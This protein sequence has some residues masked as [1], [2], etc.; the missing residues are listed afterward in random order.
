MNILGPGQ[1]RRWWGNRPAL[2]RQQSL[3]ADQCLLISTQDYPSLLQ[4]SERQ[5]SLPVDGQALQQA[6]A[7]YLTNSWLVIEAGTRCLNDSLLLF[8]GYRLQHPEIQV[9]YSDAL[10]GDSVEDAQLLLK[11]DCN[12]D[13]L[14]SRHYPGE[15]MLVT[16]ECIKR[17]LPQISVRHELIFCELIW[18]I[19]EHSGPAA[20]GHLP[21]A[22]LRIPERAVKDTHTALRREITH[23]HL[24]RCCSDS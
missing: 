19:L 21:E 16:G 22:L 4:G 11:P 1:G 24:Q 6:I 20:V 5:L 13:L 3:K 18:Q 17:Y 8:A 7:G 12:I 10:Q 2:V 23:R 15:E 14:R 9:C